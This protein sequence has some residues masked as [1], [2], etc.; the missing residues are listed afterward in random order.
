[1]SMAAI[2]RAAAQ[3]LMPPPMLDLAEWSEENI[4]LSREDS[5]APGKYI[6]WAFQIEPMQVMSPKN[7]VEK[8]CIIAA[9]QT[10]KTRLMLNFLGYVIDVD[11]GPVLFVEPRGADAEALSKDRVTPMIRDTPCLRGKVADA[12]SRDSAN[13]IDHKKFP[14]GHISFGIAT[15][16]SSL[17]MRPIRYLFLDEVSRDEYRNSSEGDP[18]SI[19]EKRTVTFW[20]RKIIYASSPGDEGTCRIS[21]LFSHS[22]QRQWH[23]PCP[24]CGHEQ[25]LEWSGIVWSRGGQPIEYTH[26]GQRCQ[27]VI[28]DTKPMYRCAECNDLIAERYK[29]EGGRYIVTNP[30]GKYPGFRVNAL[31]TPVRTWADIV[32]DYV[33]AEGK[34]SM[35]KVFY[36]TVLAETW[37]EKGEAPDWEKL[38]ARRSQWAA[39]TVPHGGLLLT[40]G[41]DVQNDRWEAFV[42][43]WGRNRQCWLVEHKVHY[44]KFSEQ[45]TKDALTLWKSQSWTHVAGASMTLARLAIDSG[46]E[47]NEVYAW[48]RTQGSDVLVIDGRQ[49]LTGNVVG[50]PSYVDVTVGGKR[51]RRGMR[52][53]PIDTWKLKNE[54]YGRLN[55]PLEGET[56]PPGWVFLPD[57]AGP[58]LCKGLVAEQIVRRIVKGYPKLSF[59]KVFPR[60]EP[61]DCWVYARAAAANL[62]IDRF[63]ERQWTS[64]ARMLSVEAEVPPPV[65]VEPV[66]DS[67]VPTA[68]PLQPVTQQQTP[69]VARQKPPR[70]VRSSFVWR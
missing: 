4:I 18:V 53:W 35:M 15:S 58:E 30:D 17:A 44:G 24:H 25:V 64:L 21:Q 31:V 9:S 2:R 48:A 26:H 1:M 62:E 20:N 42:W 45:S 66:V 38:M 60:N 43:A 5:A 54:L 28:P 14:G 37:Q 56:K 41:V 67:P 3:A 52:L 36:N 33:Q 40:A 19:A 6:P 47:T 68:A 16:P 7:P 55:L 46:H 22:D 12:K 34:P 32:Q 59:E 70:I 49:H 61:L 65:V 29:L 51:Y 57:W 63:S 11:P 69:P 27:M 13:T 23:I 39:G 10:L 50:A 8:V